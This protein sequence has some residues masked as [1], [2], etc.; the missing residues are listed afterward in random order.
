MF[1]LREI[2]GWAL[3]AVGLYVFYIAIMLLLRQGPFILEA[4]ELIAIGFIVFRGG[5]HVLKVSVA[6]RVCIE[7][8]KAALS[9][10]IKQRGAAKSVSR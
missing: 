3:V 1:W 5:L 10:D 2:L 6:G 4:P 9:H 7:A 8:Q